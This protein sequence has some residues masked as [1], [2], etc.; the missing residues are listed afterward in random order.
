MEALAAAGIGGPVLQG[1]KKA[2]S[3][4]HDNFIAMQKNLRNNSLDV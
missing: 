1:G 3:Q 2:S 4:E